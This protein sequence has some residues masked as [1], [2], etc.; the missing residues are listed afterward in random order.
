MMKKVLTLVLALAL[1][2]WAGT[3]ALAQERAYS[4]E[5]MLALTLED[6]YRAKA[7]YEAVVAR[8]GQVTPFIN[9]INAEQ[10]HIDM[11]TNLMTSKGILVAPVIQPAQAPDTLEQAL[12]A[13]AEAEVANI[14]LYE[15]ML[16]QDNVPQDVQALFTRL[17]GASR[18]HLRAFTGMNGR[19]GRVWAQESAQLPSQEETA[20]AAE[21]TGE[22]IAREDVPDESAW[23]GKEDAD[24]S[25]FVPGQGR[26]RGQNRGQGQPGMGARGGQRPFGQGQGMRRN[27]P[28]GSQ[29]NGQ[30][31]G[32]RGFGNG[33]QQPFGRGQ[34]M[35]GSCPLN[36]QSNGHG[37][38]GRN[39][40]HGRG[41]GQGNTRRG[42]MPQCPCDQCPL[43]TPAQ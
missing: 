35:G 18:Q 42:N 12:Q 5:E 4:A 34:G 22:E 26:G 15:K 37:L 10:N 38:G 31:F 20:T 30:G 16:A 9:L 17:M 33:S 7:M 14:A 40:P 13:G 27:F 11:L 24:D 39:M 25:A 41:F 32:N 43:N 36:G 6:E 28:F 29:G 23:E 19:G 21:E 2:L 8:Y 1:V 3:A